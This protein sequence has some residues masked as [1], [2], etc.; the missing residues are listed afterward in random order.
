MAP[1]RIQEIYLYH[2][3]DALRASPFAVSVRERPHH[4]VAPVAVQTAV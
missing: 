4:P 3:A 2:M 1:E